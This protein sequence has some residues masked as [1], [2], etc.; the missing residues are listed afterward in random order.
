MNELAHFCRFKVYER[1]EHPQAIKKQSFWGGE[2][3]FCVSKSTNAGHDF[4][5]KW[6]EFTRNDSEPTLI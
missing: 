6:T 2:E 3:Y 4:S 1:S 5:L